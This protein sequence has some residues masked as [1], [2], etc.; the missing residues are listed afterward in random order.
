MLLAIVAGLV[1]RLWLLH[2]QPLSS[3]EAVVGL[4]ADQIRHGHFYTFYWGQQYGGVE[5][6]VVAL[7][8]AVAGR[9]PLVLNAVPTLLWALACVFVWRAGRYLLPDGWGI[10]AAA[11]AVAMWVA[12]PMAYLSNTHELG[13]HAVTV[14]LGVAL[15]WAALRVGRSP[16]AAN[17][18]LA[19]LIAGLGWWSS[20]EI[21]YFI[22]P[23]LGALA[24]GSLW[25]AHWRIAIPAL[26]AGGLLGAAPWLATNIRTGFES[27]NL[28]TSPGQGTSSYLGRLGTFFTKSLPLEL[29]VRKPYSFTWLIG[30]AGRVIY[31]VALLLIVGLCVIA[32]AWPSTTPNRRSVRL[33]GAGVLLFPFEY[34][35]LPATSY[36]KDGRYAIYLIPLLALLAL[37]TAEPVARW[38]RGW[39]GAVVVGGSWFAVVG[40]LSGVAFTSSF[41]N[42]DPGNLSLGW[43]N[44]DAAAQASIRTLSQSGVHY[45]LADYWTAYTVDYI[46]HGALQVAPTRRVRWTAQLRL[47]LSQPGY[48]FLFFGPGENGLD[49]WEFGGEPGPNGVDETKFVALLQGQH[50]RYSVVRAGVLDAVVVPPRTSR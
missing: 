16:I 15:V 35:T 21:V 43:G 47:V 18:F 9:S 26:T 19:G 33:I 10:T 42:N 2:V 1:G 31:V 7:V 38:V 34:A 3:D 17:Y 20:P 24:A 37:V 27:L 28:D 46:S 14:T 30:G 50:D 22:L 11:I 13:V 48:S 5:P 12:T 4:M 44:P 8:A 29:G 6:Y 25:P 40:V 41:L 36:W 45:A 49:S 23:A 32:L 39:S